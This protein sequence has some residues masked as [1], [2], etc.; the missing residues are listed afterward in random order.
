MQTGERLGAYEIVAPL[1]AGGMGEVWRAKDLR[2][3]RE[4]AIKLLSPAILHSREIVSRF[5]REARALAALNHPRVAVLHGLEES[6]DTRFLVME[7]VDG[8]TLERRLAR[9]LPVDEAIAM[10]LQI[11]EA[12]E[13]AHQKGIIHRD[14]KPANVMIGP[15]GDV[16]LLDFGLSKLLHTLGP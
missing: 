15:R 6:G 13:A 16:K 12:L 10:A 4:V 5:E 14:L 9:P 11:A 7:L 3:G 1:G 8:E 2:L